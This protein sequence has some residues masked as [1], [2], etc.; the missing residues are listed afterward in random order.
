[1]TAVADSKPASTGR[2]PLAKAFKND[3]QLI[4]SSEVDAVII[5]TSHFD[6]TTLGSAALAAGLHV[7]VE[8]P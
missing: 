7:L 4:A 3:Q 1:M 8:K 6:L 5:A 2:F